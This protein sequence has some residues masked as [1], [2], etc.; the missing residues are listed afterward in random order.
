MSRVRI[1]S[2][3]VDPV[4]MREAVDRCLAFIEEGG[5]HLVVTPNA[6]IAYNA[7]HDSSLAEIINGA[8][9]VI[10]DG[11]G[12][13]M[14]SR[15]LGDPVP[16]KV[17]GTDLATNLLKELNAQKRGRVFLFGTKPE[18]VA[19]AA[20]RLKERYPGITIAG[21]RD[22][23]FKPEEEP[24]IIAQIRAARA[25]LLF[26][27]LGSPK[28]ERWLAKH[29]PELGVKVGIGVGGTIDVWAG[30]VPRAPEWVQKLGFEWLYRI[31]KFGRYSRSLPPLFK[32]GLAVVGKRLRGR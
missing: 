6:E 24:E 15:I 23:F 29:L 5:P 31:V 14:A 17:A 32:F 20:R 18:V 9:L 7:A 16:E 12:I 19:E 11:I 1:L 8:D 21:Y 26:V 2:I 4:T 13:V 27:A 22:G 28:Q 10:P 3:G 30:A 25:D